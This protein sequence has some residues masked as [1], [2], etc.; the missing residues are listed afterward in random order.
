M[1]SAKKLTIILLLLTLLLIAI[2]VIKPTGTKHHI[3]VQ[4]LENTLTQSLDGH[5]RYFLIDSQMTGK[6]LIAVPPTTQCQNSSV[7]TIE[8]SARQGEP[9]HYR[10]I[11]CP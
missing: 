6:Q 5:R 8:Q 7:I 11:S 1:S 10:F 9:P 4:L 2:V 3:Q